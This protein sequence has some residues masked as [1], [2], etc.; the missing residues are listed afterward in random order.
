PLHELGG[1][2]VGAVPVDDAALGTLVAEEDVL[3]DRQ[4]R[5]ERQ[6]LVDDDD[7]GVLAVA[8]AAELALP[9]VEDDLT[10]VRAVRVDAGQHLHQR[11]L[12]GAV[13]TADGVD[14]TAAHG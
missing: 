7:A 5:A 11:R 12:P 4:L 6:L 10:L 9:P 3:R 14:L 2:V 1:L 8:D 13:L